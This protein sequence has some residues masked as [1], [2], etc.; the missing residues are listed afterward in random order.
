MIEIY[1]NLHIGHQADYDW[2]VS[3]RSGW[4]TVHACKEPYHRQALGYSGRA[5][6]KSH[7]EY[8]MAYR[9]NRL[10]LNMIDAPRPD[11]I[12]REIV[13]AA[14]T[15]AHEHLSQGHPVLV[16]CN[17]GQSRSAAIGML[18]LG[19]YTEE[20]PYPDFF[21]AEEVF[22]EMYPPY[23]PATGVRGFEI[24]VLSNSTP[25]LRQ[26]SRC[27]RCHESAGQ[28]PHNLLHSLGRGNQPRRPMHTTRPCSN[29]ISSPFS[30]SRSATY[31][32]IRRP[33]PG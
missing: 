8:L 29:L 7:P 32:L 17:Q 19:S 26:K 18:Y 20:L 30:W 25:E 23:A 6:P 27:H 5:A 9:G 1:P 16:H 4:F 33:D 2:D 31:S 21:Q 11:Y 12:P 3:R 28:S 10:I 22:R 24:P 13:D 15:F 14:L